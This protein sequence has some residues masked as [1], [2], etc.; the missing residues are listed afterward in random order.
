MTF[1]PQHYKMCISVTETPCDRSITH[2]MKLYVHSL[3][4]DCKWNNKTTFVTFNKS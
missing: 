3:Q 4:L 1:G 2:F